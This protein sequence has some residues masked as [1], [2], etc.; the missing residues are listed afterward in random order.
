VVDESNST[1]PALHQQAYE[2]PSSGKRSEKV[3]RAMGCRKPTPQ[4]LAFGTPFV[5]GSNAYFLR[6]VE[7][8]LILHDTS[9]SITAIRYQTVSRVIED[10]AY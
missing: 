2:M 1:R 5:T 10:N 6:F 3:S 4:N 9:C 7:Y 8:A